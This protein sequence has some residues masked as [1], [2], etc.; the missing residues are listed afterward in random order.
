MAKFEI[1]KKVFEEI[2]KEL[3]MSKK[4][5]K[6]DVVNICYGMVDA[7]EI[8]LKGMSENAGAMITITIPK[9]SFIEYGYETPVK[10]VC[11][12]LDIL[13]TN[14]EMF[15]SVT[16]L[17]I[18]LNKETIE[19]CGGN[20]CF[21]L[22]L[23]DAEFKNYDGLSY[24]DAM[25]IKFNLQAFKS[26]S[27]SIKKK[28]NEE[29]IKVKANS[30]TKKL[31]ITHN[32]NEF[33]QNT[34]EINLDYEC[35]FSYPLIDAVRNV[36]AEECELLLKYDSDLFERFKIKAAYPM[37]I[38]ADLKTYSVHIDVAPYNID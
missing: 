11:E 4:Y 14:L 34:P 21:S 32:K 36:N 27:K 15:K 22:P 9:T 6:D 17:S 29:H 13:E 31:I 2:F 1:N 12:K 28:D 33:I 38:E 18:S 7:D 37:G 10:F 16:D 25:R 35:N 3:R 5:N 20:S 30:D 24:N 23:S 26:F 8:R 19:F